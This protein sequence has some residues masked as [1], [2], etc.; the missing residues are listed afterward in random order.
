MEKIKLS[1][2]EPTY[3]IN[4]DKKT[5]TC[6]VEFLIKGNPRIL[7]YLDH[8][9]F[10][11]K[12]ELLTGYHTA[13]A[14]AKLNPMDQ[15]DVNTGIKVARAKAESWAY[16]MVNSHI[17]NTLKKCMVEVYDVVKDFEEKASNVKE[18]NNKYI[19]SF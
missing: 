1:F 13:I 8:V 17:K 2:E 3:F 6:K 5:V 10:A 7:N 11:Y 9:S 14:T 15:F 19:Q 18:H 16:Q 4:H 12:N